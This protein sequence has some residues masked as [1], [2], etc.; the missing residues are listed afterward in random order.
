[1]AFPL[2]GRE[3]EKHVYRS[4]KF[5]PK[6]FV[7][8]AASVSA[9][10]SSSQD[11]LAPKAGLRQILITKEMAPIFRGREEELKESFSMLISVLDGKGFT[12]DT[13]MRGQRG[14]MTGRFC[15]TG[16]ARQLRCLLLLTA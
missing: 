15:S 13:G 5:T 1:M 11:R 8:H 14:I 2:K 16:S 3:L 4:D 7:S 6:A 9:A 10:G 12:S